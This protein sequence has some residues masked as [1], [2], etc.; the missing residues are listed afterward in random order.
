MTRVEGTTLWFH[1]RR[2]EQDARLDYKFVVN[3]NSWILDPRN[4]LHVSGGFGPNSELRMPGY[5][6]APEIQYYPT[7]PHGSLR[8]TTWASV[9]LGN[10]RTIR[11]YTPPGYDVQTES[12]PVVYVHDGQEYVT[13]ASAHNVLDYLVSEGKIEPVIGVFIPPVNRT[14]EYAGSSMTQFARF[15]VEE[16]VPYIDTRYRT[17]RSPESRAVLGASNGG[18][19]SLWLGYQHPEVF[20][21]VA[22]YSTNIVDSLSRGFTSSA[23][24]PLTLYL[25]LG[26]YDIAVL[27][28]LVRGFIPILESKGY[29]HEYREYHEGHSWG[30]W[31][32]HLNNSLEMFFG[33]NT[34]MRDLPEDHTVPGGLELHQNFPN[35]FNPTTVVR[36]S[37]PVVGEMRLAV[38]DALGREVAVLAEERKEAGHHELVFDATRHGGQAGGLASGVYFYRLTS[39]N[40]TQ[41]KSLILLK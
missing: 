15:M 30:N 7:I 14:A 36:Y 40:F 41:T 37:L 32:A 31:R 29:P 5:V 21:N 26:T 24:K 39:G 2:F 35:P 27:I 6:P 38:Y 11:I 33:T 23:R 34:S 18:N 13:L 8:D 20:G 19:I 1:T 10:S 25:D 28:P 17:R 22:A 16:I 9:N 12:Y 4:A 3:G